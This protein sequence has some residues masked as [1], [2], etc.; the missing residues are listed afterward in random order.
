MRL[1]VNGE[2]KTLSP[3]PPTLREALLA[4]GL[5]PEMLLVEYNG[6]ALHRSEWDTIVPKEGDRLELLRVVAGG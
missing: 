1:E 2:W 4:M 6:T 3:A 5:V